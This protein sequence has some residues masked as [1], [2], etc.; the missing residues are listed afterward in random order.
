MDREKLEK[1]FYALPDVKK[2][3]IVM[4]CVYKT[5]EMCKEPKYR[6][7]QDAMSGVISYKIA[8]S[9]MEDSQNDV[10]RI[11]RVCVESGLISEGDAQQLSNQW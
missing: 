11:Y 10:L 6:A 8:C 1:L 2:F 7:Y 3:E 9:I 4:K 5:I